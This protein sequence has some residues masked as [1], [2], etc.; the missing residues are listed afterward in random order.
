MSMPSLSLANS[1]GLFLLYPSM[2]A[3]RVLG[4]EEKMYIITVLNNISSEVPVAE[5]LAKYILEFELNP[6]DQKCFSAKA[7]AYGNLCEDTEI[8]G[9]GP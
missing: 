8:W 5:Q 6:A 9:T 1:G 7:H 4:M 3:V 2:G